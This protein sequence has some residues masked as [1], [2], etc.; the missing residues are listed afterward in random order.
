MDLRSFNSQADAFE[1]GSRPE[2][3]RLFTY[4]HP[5]YQPEWQAYQDDQYASI[6][7]N[8]RECLGESAYRPLVSYFRFRADSSLSSF[9]TMTLITRLDNPTH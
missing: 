8:D 3:Y 6:F 2:S 1:F 7:F 5:Q 4:Y 9:T